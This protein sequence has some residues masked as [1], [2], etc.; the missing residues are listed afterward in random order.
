[1]EFCCGGRLLDEVAR[2]SPPRRQC[3]QEDHGRPQVLPRDG[4]RAQGHQA[5]ECS[6]HQG[7]K[8]EASGFQIGRAGF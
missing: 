2:G 7:Q 6:A 4:R 5:G 3:D 8:V 1:M